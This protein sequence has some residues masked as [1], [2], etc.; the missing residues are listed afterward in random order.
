MDNCEHLVDAI[1]ELVAGLLA[2]APDVRVLATSRQPL[3]L[4]GEHLL[5]V[6]PL[7]V[8]SPEDVASGP[9]GHVEAVA[10]LV[11]R[12]SAVDRGFQVDRT[13]AELIARLCRRLD[14]VPLAI[15]LAAA[16]LRVLSLSQL[17]ERLDDRF[18]LLT[19]GPRAAELRHQT[20]RG[21]IDWSYELCSPD[22]Q[23]VWA[24][25][26]VFEGGA[27]VDAVEAVCAD[28]G[29]A[30]F[31]A[32]AGLVDKS[33]LVP[34]EV[35]GRVRYRM[36]ETIRSY[37]RERLADRGETGEL[38][39]RHRDYYVS[40]ARTTE[41]SSFSPRQ[42]DRFARTAAELPNLRVAHEACLATPETSP[43]AAV[44]SSSLYWHWVG[45]G[46][47]DEGIRWADR[48]IAG[49]AGSSPES[50]RAVLRA[51][52]LSLMTQHFE[53]AR[54]YA[55]R[56]FELAAAEGSEAG[57]IHARSAKA[58]I[59][60]L[61]GDI[62]GAMSLDR[63]NLSPGFSS[64]QFGAEISVGTLMRSSILRA[65]TGRAA[66]ALV[67]L[68]EALDICRT[69][70]E[71]YWRGLLLCL[72]GARL[73]DLGRHQE[74]LVSVHE[75]LRLAV[76]FNA[77][78]VANALEVAAQVTAHFGDA[79]KSA[80]ALGALSG[81]W[82]SMGS[83]PLGEDPSKRGT[84][85][86]QARDVL[87]DAVYASAYDRGRSMPVEEVVSFVLGETS[88]SASAPE[89]AGG[90]SAPELSRRELEVAE[91]IA[92]GLSN[93]EISETLVISP[94][95]AEGHVARL[96]DKLGFTSRARVAAW[97]AEQRALDNTP[98]LVAQPPGVLP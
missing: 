26:S 73:A 12:A 45:D 30:V 67:D 31:D 2:A 56:A 53:N 33:V 58:I 84:A 96:L 15:E 79:T 41:Q 47:L 80:V 88:A 50:I 18:A 23:A 11:D 69:Y 32:L 20:L 35:A 10:L 57:Q 93:K 13:N 98:S 90:S 19:S 62:D 7:S 21:L 25:M 6:P 9:I 1:A 65:L 16:R 94:R 86:H 27:D 68:D 38:A 77:F 87:G 42:R 72:R 92:R 34:G 61:D 49:S 82:P 8:P 54:P 83:S 39:G 95:T 28:P 17:V 81:I 5:T 44:I 48:T 70:D 74:A 24:R 46:A 85:E 3:A 51:A 66:E 89:L 76:G 43:G 37:G 59:A 14:G 75:S 64:S 78:T 29:I 71:E 91:L 63:G 40:F 22:E 97:V 55:E 52:W 60:F 4:E 36:L